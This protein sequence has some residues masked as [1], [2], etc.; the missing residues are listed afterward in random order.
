MAEKTLT[1]IK[2]TAF[3][4]LAALCSVGFVGYL[5]MQPHH[6]VA[7]ALSKPKIELAERP[8]LGDT[9]MKQTNPHIFLSPVPV[10]QSAP[11]FKVKDAS[12]KMVS[13][14]GFKGKKNVVLIFYQGDFCRVCGAQL[15]N[16]QSNLK[17][18][19]DYDAE[20]LAISS[21]PIEKARKTF[22]EHGLSFSVLPDEQLKIINQF[23][24]PNV[25][26]NIAWPS[27]F[28]IDKAGIVKLSYADPDFK[29]LY[30]PELLKALEVITEKK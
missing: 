18:F 24:V 20:I 7:H 21:D 13:L 29:R 8:S 12:G 17:A 2:R 28:I 22:G 4:L 19:Q 5:S 27:V 26:R 6:N 15:D 30:S 11:D 16:L 14:S 10:G 3:V 1:S 25:K 23:G 9:M